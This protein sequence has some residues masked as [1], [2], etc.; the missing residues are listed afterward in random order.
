MPSSTSK[1]DSKILPT[2]KAGGGIVTPR[3]QAHWIV[4]E[5]GAVDL[6]GRSMQER[7][8][9]LTSIAHPDHR[10]ELERVAFERFGPHY[11]RVK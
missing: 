6:Y 3:A 1:G 2:I 4:T 8:R 11:L 9:L 5:Y 10:E 7:A